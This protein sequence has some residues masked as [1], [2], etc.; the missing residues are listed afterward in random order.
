MRLPDSTHTSRPWRIHE[1]VGD[2]RLEDVW[3]LPTPGSREDFPRLVQLIAS[4]DPSRGT[5]RTARMLWAIR[6]KLGG[7]LGWD[8]PPGGRGSAPDTPRPPAGRSAR[9][10]GRAGLRRAPVHLAVPDRRRV[11]GGD[12][13]PDCARGHAHRLGARRAQG[14]PRRDGRVREAE[15]TAWELVPGRDQ[16][17]PAPD[18]V[19]ADAAPDR[20]GLAAASQ[21]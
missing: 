16:A 6:W 10:P 7:L 18:R 2:F 8:R 11:G 5:S 14:V 1:L 9:R 3:T 13:Q 17:V 4:G 19:P 20:A 15:R 21:I 12:R